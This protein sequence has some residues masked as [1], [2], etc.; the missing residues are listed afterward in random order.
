MKDENAF[1]QYLGKELTK[2][3]Q[4]RLYHMKAADKFR[5]G[6]SDFLIWKTF[7]SAAVECKFVGGKEQ[8]NSDSKKKLLSH[9]FTGEQIT[10]L[11]S[12][13]RTGNRAWGLVFFN[14]AKQMIL[15]P[16]D[17]IPEGGN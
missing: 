4:Q 5:S 13:A 6:V 10:F 12:I 2:M 15:I 17:K 3:H 9:P 1:N 11:E 16:W 8:L 14:F 7:T